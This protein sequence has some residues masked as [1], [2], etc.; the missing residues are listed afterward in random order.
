MTICFFL[1][2]LIF[3][4]N[5][6][7]HTFQIFDN[8][9]ASGFALLWLSFWEAVAIGWGYGG[10]KYLQTV[11]RM[12]GKSTVPSALCQRKT[13]SETGFLTQNP[14]KLLD[15]DFQGRISDRKAE[16]ILRR[17]Q[18]SRQDHRQSFGTEQGA[19]SCLRT[20]LRSC[21]KSCL[22]LKNLF[23]CPVLNSAL[24]NSVQ[25]PI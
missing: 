13:G 23:C 8:F 5:G 17:R 16:Q 25:K 15:R 3:C 11:E 19:L 12:T 7:V 20:C 24:K 4:T 14:D 10:E 18:D 6:G 22:R 1:I 21:L 2:G 9:G